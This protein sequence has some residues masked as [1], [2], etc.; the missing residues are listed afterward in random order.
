VGAGFVVVLD[1]LGKNPPQMILVEDDD[2][3]EAFTADTPVQPLRVGTLPRAVRR[4]EYV[5]DAHVLHPP[6]KLVAIDLVVVAEQLLGCGVPGKGLR[7][8]LRRPR[9]RRVFRQ[10]EVE[11]VAAFKGQDEENAEDL[12]SDRWDH[13]EVD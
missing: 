10:R 9:C 4:G 13:Q 3:V 1:V 5:L 12:E 7:D 2:M 6:S 11:N 8:L